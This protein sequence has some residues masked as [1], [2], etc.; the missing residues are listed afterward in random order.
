MNRGFY[1]IMAAQFFSSLADNALLFVAIDILVTMNAPA[2]LTPLLKLSFVLFYVLLAA[3]VGAFA[4]AMLK[5]R[6]MFIAN[7]IKIFGCALMFMEVHPLLSYAVVGFGA[8]VY[9]PA[10]YGIL[11]ELLPP[12]KLV[13]A[14]GWIE[15]LTVMSIIFGT[16]LGGALVS[17][18]GSAFLVGLHVP[19]IN[20]TSEAAMAV[21][22]GIYIL[23][24]LFNLR[25]P[26]TGARYEHQE[27]NPMKLI[28]DF[29]NCSATLWKDKLGQ[30]SLAITTLF[31]GA[32]ATL[33]FI[34]LKWAERSLDMP[35]DKATNL[36][37]VVAIGVAVGAALAAKI[38]PLK[39]SLTVIPMGI[40]MGLVVTVMV[41]VYDVAVAYPLLALI[42][43][44]SGY[45]VVPMN[46][47]LQ[48]R[49]HVLMSAGHSIA[50]QNFNENL[51]ILTMLAM[52][53]IMITLNLD[54][55]VI[56][57]IF[58]L[59]IAG[60][61]YLILRRHQRNQAQHDSLALIGE[62]KH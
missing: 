25:I 3:F 42:G 7:L 55:N 45:F 57:V 47:L 23:A 53:A 1:T 59:S 24:A 39:K 51:S 56:I 2:S 10:K 18:A 54:L 52:Y 14:N 36:I 26:D 38:V 16:V 21:V 5:G 40:L 17:Q 62:H 28:A 35:L 34:V 9:S 58:G 37:G 46:A 60:I 50:V 61:T 4:D 6:V 48:H 12:E 44:L 8:A 41:F 33:Q 30:I 11:T 49:G 22:V 27:R 32:G 13:A 15:G 31:W 43:F 20:T 19:G 29:A